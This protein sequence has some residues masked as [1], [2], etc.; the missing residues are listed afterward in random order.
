MHIPSAL[1]GTKTKTIARRRPRYPL[2]GHILSI[3]EHV[4]TG[5][6]RVTAGDSETL[7]VSEMSGNGLWAYPDERSCENNKRGNVV[8]GCGGV[9]RGDSG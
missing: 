3:V 4:R 9:V 8:S 1:R 6:Y 7:R 2:G 5:S